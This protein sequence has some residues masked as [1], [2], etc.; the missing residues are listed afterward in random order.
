[1]ALNTI[2]L[3]TL[4]GKVLLAD[5]VCDVENYQNQKHGSKLLVSLQIIGQILNP[6]LSKVQRL[7]SNTATI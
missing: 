5:H 6:S 1:M 7:G 4:C 3:A 2:A